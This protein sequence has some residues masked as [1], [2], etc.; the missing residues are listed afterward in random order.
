MEHE[1][2]SLW[3]MHDIPA[4]QV[5]GALVGVEGDAIVAKS[6]DSSGNIGIVDDVS[7][8]IRDRDGVYATELIQIEALERAAVFDKKC[9]VQRR[10]R[11][12]RGRK[13]AWRESADRLRIRRI[14]NGPIVRINESA[15]WVEMNPVVER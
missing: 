1:S 5:Y 8:E 6:D 7:L 2:Q 13:V 15:S 12:H 14:Y 3:L 4:D 11:Y 9:L 10:I